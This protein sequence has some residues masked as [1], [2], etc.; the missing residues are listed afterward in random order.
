LGLALKLVLLG[1]AWVSWSALHSGLATPRVARWVDRH[2][3]RWS[4]CWRLCYNVVSLATI[5]PVVYFESALRTHP[6]LPWWGPLK[7][8]QVL[9]WVLSAVLL[10]LGGRA[11]DVWTFLGFRQIAEAHTAPEEQ[12]PREL[13]TTGVLGLVRHHP[14]PLVA[15]PGRREPGAER[16]PD[17]LSGAG[18]QAGGAP[19]AGRVRRAIPRVPGAGAD[20]DPA[21][22]AVGPG[23]TA[24]GGRRA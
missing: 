20:A 8:V 16:D 1:L 12:E 17:A 21:M 24:G 2:W 9:I 13:V 5:V 11:Y 10:I 7:A 14:P 6:L 18:R 19:A 4:V 15:R 22:A 23:E 3:G